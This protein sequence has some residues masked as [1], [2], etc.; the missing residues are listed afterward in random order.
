MV[1]FCRVSR[2]CTP[3]KVSTHFEMCSEE[4]GKPKHSVRV[5]G[6]RWDEN[7]LFLLIQICKVLRVIV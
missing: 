1:V 3:V 5:G 4:S 7:N 2:Y 6:C